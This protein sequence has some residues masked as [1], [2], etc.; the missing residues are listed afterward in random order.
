MLQFEAHH[1]RLRECNGMTAKAG[2]KAEKF[3]V[4]FCG[5]DSHGERENEPDNKPH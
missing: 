2:E 5:N 3:A 1:E 4:A